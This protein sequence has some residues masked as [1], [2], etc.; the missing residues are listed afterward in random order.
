MNTARTTDDRVRD[1]VRVAAGWGLGLLLPVVVFCALVAFTSER[2]GRC[3]AYG[4]DCS[5]VPDQLLYGSF[6]TSLVAGAAVLAWPRTRWAG[7]RVGAV[8][9]QW[10]AQLLLAALI[11][12]YA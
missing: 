4:Q 7:A 3:L 8:L 2:A 12:S 9:V 1:D 11:L 10:G 5:P 6:W